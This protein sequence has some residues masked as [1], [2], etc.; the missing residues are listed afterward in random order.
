MEQGATGLAWL[1]QP[2]GNGD[3]IYRESDCLEYFCRNR[4][5]Q[6]AFRHVSTYD[7]KSAT[8]PEDHIEM[9]E[10]WLVQLYMLPRL[11]AH[12]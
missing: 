12:L 5:N 7:A 2:M 4:T 1:I 10:L 9:E 3:E 8:D 11:C 6:H